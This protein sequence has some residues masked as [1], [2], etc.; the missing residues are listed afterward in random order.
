M[1]PA[2]TIVWP[3]RCRASVSEARKTITF[4]TSSTR[5]IWGKAM[6]AVT[7]R[8]SAASCRWGTVIGVTV[9]PGQTQL[10]RPPQ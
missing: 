10:T 1:P 6:V 7:R 5:A 8:T 2:T 4:A 9:Q 3:L